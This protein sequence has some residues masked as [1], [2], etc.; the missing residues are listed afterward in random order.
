VRAAAASSATYAPIEWPISSTLSPGRAGESADVSAVFVDVV[1]K[2]QES[3]EVC[4]LVV[5][6]GQVIAVRAVVTWAQLLSRAYKG[7]ERPSAHNRRSR[8]V[9]ILGAQRLRRPGWRRLGWA[10]DRSGHRGPG[11]Q[12][13]TQPSPGG[14]TG[15]AVVGAL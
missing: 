4:L 7:P 14:G 10:E 9:R 2:V 12:V 1:E 8:A 6:M 3:L 15:S 11:S 5:D 13:A